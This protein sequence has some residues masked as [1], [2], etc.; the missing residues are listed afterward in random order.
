MVSFLQI[1]G[2]T[3]SYGDRILFEDLTLGIYQGDK[4]GLIA[5][6]GTGKST[7]LKIIA[8]EEDYDSGRVI[9]RN[10]L[11]IGYLPQTPAIRAD[12]T[13]L[14]YLFEG[15]DLEHDPSIEERGKKLL[16]QL[17]ITNLN[18]KMGSMSG[19]QIKRL[20]LA[21]T[22]LIEPELLILDEPTNHLDIKM[23]EWLENFL[24][25]SYMT[26]LMVTHD[27]YFLD[28]ICNKIIEID[29]N[30]LYVY[31]GNYSY[32]IEKRDERY[33]TMNAELEKV[34]NILRKEL[35]WMR[36]QPQARGTK[37]KYR[38]DNFYKLEEKSKV[39]LNQK[40]INFGKNKNYIG[41]KIFDAKNVSKAFGDLKILKDWNY[42]FSRYEKLGIVGDN[43]TGKTTFIRLLL[44]ELTP[45]S[46]SFDIGSTVRWGYYSQE[47]MT[48]FDK[49]KKVI[50]AVTE[51]A[52][53][54]RLDEKTVISASQFLTRFLF[55]PSTQQKY[56]HTLSGGELRRLYLATVLLRNPNFLILDEPTN[57]LD[58][59]T[60]SILE[61]YLSDFK[62]CLIVVSH[63]R[64]FLD[65]V[66]D[67][68][69]VFKGNGE[70]K[71]F[72]G[73]YSDFRRQ[74]QT[75][76]LEENEKIKE[77]NKTI[78]TKNKEKE[79]K[80]K[81]SF[82]EKREMEELSFRLDEMN[83]EKARLEGDMS[84]GELDHTQL[85]A[86]GQRIQ[87]LITM[88]DE[89]EMRLLELMEKEEA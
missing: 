82:K 78:E 84:T 38:I 13:P 86:H 68:I 14:E 60:L 34:R 88:I 20:A 41:S 29:R 35:E 16:H 53:N 8:G 52:E 74:E 31:E 32:Y 33:K 21:K 73:S 39:N 36:R 77:A 7:F 43:G 87:E 27:R 51:I 56:I 59:T 83:E 4:I 47:G 45:D 79:R 42:T 11:K 22:L 24:S 19:G 65:R 2:L 1:E 3:K 58:I 64:F 48:N 55:S 46:G 10:G 66:A 49:N 5:P 40:E 30:R 70:I 67:H 80:V 85:T 75:E 12:Y 61:D 69:L 28:N 17:R 89:A 44:G 6:N 37:A 76:R 9:F 63:D 25:K 71:D 62:G 23:V 18:Q 26:V 50:D 54:I 81:L 57:D 15:E 72:P